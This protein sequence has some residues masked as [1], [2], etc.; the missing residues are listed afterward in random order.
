MPQGYNGLPSYYS[1]SS[2]PIT[3]N[4]GLSLIGMDPIIAEDFVLI[5]TAFA[6]S[7]AGTVTSFSVG[8]LSPLFTTSVATPTTTPALT[9]S[10]STQAANSVFAGPVS[11]GVAGPTFRT[12]VAA[13]I[14]AGITNTSLAV[15]QV[16]HGFT[17]GQAVY[18]NGT[19]WVLAEA[20]AIGTLGLGLVIIV[21]GA[22]DFTV[23]FEGFVTGLSGL[24]AGQYYF[25]SDAT[26]GALTVTEPVATTSFSNPLL[27]AISATTGTVLDHRPSS[28]GSTVI[29]PTFT[30]VTVT[31]NSNAVAGQLILVNT[32]SGGFTVTL[33]LSSANTGQII[34][35]KKVSTD[36]NTVT[37]GRTGSDLI[38]GQTLQSFTL[39]YTSATFVSDGAGNWWI[40]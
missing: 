18:F 26:P 12:L 25:V 16:A 35:I 8:A 19:I 20:N 4:L 27:F 15:H 21:P 31:N 11:G 6:G 13:D 5:D 24:T 22:N 14:P 3:P 32:G 1:G 38:D 36:G 9:F 17:V 7:G 40:T 29:T 28:I 33:P 39:A 2:N 34:T 30:V 37:I 10:L 23:C